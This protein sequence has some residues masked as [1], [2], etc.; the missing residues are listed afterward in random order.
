M[1][2]DIIGNPGELVNIISTLAIITVS[3][4]SILGFLGSF[5]WTFDLFSHFRFQYLILLT[6]FTVLSFLFG[7]IGISIFGLTFVL[8]NLVT[9]APYYIPVRKPMPDTGGYRIL[10]SN[11]LQSNTEFGKL[12]HIIQEIRPGIMVLIEINERWM[13]ELAPVS[14]KYPYLHTEIR[15]DNHGMAIFSRYAFNNTQTLYFGDAKVPSLLAE[16]N[17]DGNALIIVGTHPPPPKSKLKN[18]HRNQQIEN[19]TDFIARQNKPTILL[20]DLNMTSWSHH[21]K[22]LINGSK[23]RD[24]RKG[25]GLQPTWPAYNPVFLVPIDHVLVSGG[26]TIHNR[27]TGPVIGSDHRPVIVDFSFD[28]STQESID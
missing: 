5:W 3:L 13:R 12:L 7:G 1:Y 28:I 27:F 26:I 9:I 18:S 6:G 11:V 24:T 17:I 19:I 25:F 22:G 4:A 15:S 10:L 2:I 21:F 14:D 8:I 20:G 23:L 16:V